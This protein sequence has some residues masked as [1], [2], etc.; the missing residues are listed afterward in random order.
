M[1]HPK[2]PS[3]K[4]KKKGKERTTYL[5]NHIKCKLQALALEHGNQVSEQDREV[6]VA[7]PEGDKDR[8]LERITA[9]AAQLG[10]SAFTP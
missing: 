2:L 8:H 7:I 9:K 4:R 1:Q 10:L 3:Q 5:F 6:L